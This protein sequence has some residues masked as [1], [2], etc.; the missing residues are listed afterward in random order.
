[1]EREEGERVGKR[2]ERGTEQALE[3]DSSSFAKMT[4][5]T[6]S[7]ELLSRGVQIQCKAGKI[8]DEEERGPL[9][10]TVSF[11][12]SNLQT[13]TVPSLLPSPSV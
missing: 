10:Q 5:A 4:F 13:S 11:A 1:M 12:R 2:R 8:V 7:N 3:Q 9:F 6:F